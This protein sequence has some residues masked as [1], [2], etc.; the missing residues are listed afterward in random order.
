MLQPEV[1]LPLVELQDTGC[2]SIN[3]A[4]AKSP[5]CRWTTVQGE[6]H[7]VKQHV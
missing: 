6:P 5:A 1:I 2:E 3:F 4:C 7:N